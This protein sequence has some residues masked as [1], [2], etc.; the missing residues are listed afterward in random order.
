MKKF[1]QKGCLILFYYFFFFV[2]KAIVSQL[3][4]S[5]LGLIVGSCTFLY[6][7][8]KHLM[9]ETPESFKDAFLY[10]TLDRG[11][12]LDFFTSHVSIHSINPLCFS[13]PTP[14]RTAVFISS[15]VCYLV[16]NE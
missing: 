14:I 5:E 16:R 1:H 6:I 15:Y 3:F 12:G 7:P 10:Y 11:P 4:F 2:K 9:E 8:Y 13:S